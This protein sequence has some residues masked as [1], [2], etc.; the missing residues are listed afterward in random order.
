MNNPLSQAIHEA[1]DAA[2][3]A[4]LPSIVEALKSSLP[5]DARINKRPSFS[6]CFVSMAKLEE[7]FNAHRST[8]R[9]RAGQGVYPP[10]RKHGMHIGYYQ[11]DLDKI[12]AK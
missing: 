10:L 2:I 3:D 5:S 4:R 6:D 1:V 8:I 7:I 11:S 12:F 9:R